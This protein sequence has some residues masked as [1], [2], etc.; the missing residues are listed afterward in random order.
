MMRDS[1]KNLHQKPGLTD[2]GLVKCVVTS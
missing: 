2:V 1:S